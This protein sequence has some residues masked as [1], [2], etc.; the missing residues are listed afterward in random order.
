MN[1]FVSNNSISIPMYVGVYSKC[2]KGN[3][4]IKLNN[5]S[6]NNYE[7]NYVLLRIRN[8]VFCIFFKLSKLDI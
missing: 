1:I 8:V 3:A 6:G 5:S 2:T 7:F 4:L